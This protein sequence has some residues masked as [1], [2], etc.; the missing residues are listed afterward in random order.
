MASS[1]RFCCRR[2][3]LSSVRLRRRS[4]VG[5]TWQGREASDA[6]RQ[7][8]CAVSSSWSGCGHLPTRP[9]QLQRRRHLLHNRSAGSRR[10]AAAAAAFPGTRGRS[11]LNQLVGR[12]VAAS[13]RK[14]KQVWSLQAAGSC[15]HLQRASKLSAAASR[16]CPRCRCWHA[17]AGRP[18]THT[19]SSGTTPPVA[20]HRIV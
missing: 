1:L 18:A 3:P 12:H 4:L 9:V 19:A 16:S 2:M 10:P 8:G 6:T 20:V 5:V 17:A 13:K 15:A 11:H 14:W 7:A